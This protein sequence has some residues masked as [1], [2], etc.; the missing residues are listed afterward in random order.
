MFIPQPLFVPQFCKGKRV[1]ESREIYLGLLIMFIPQPL[2]VPQFR[3]G[4]RVLESREIML[5]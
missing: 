3:K 4:K 5:K 1:L 2:F